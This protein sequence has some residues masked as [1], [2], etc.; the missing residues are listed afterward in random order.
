MTQ[1]E[2]I[3]EIAS[4]ASRLSDAANAYANAIRQEF[5]FS[6]VPNGPSRWEQKCSAACAEFTFALASMRGDNE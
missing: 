5:I 3:E 6:R 2:F 4:K 1:L